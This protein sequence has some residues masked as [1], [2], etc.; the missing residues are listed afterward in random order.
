MY[1]PAIRRSLF[2]FLVLIGMAS[3]VGNEHPNVLLISIDD[4]NDWVGVS[5]GGILKQARPTSIALLNGAYYSPT[6]IA[7]PRSAILHGQA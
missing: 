7:K 6:P 1:R 3:A 5:W 2:V 4:L